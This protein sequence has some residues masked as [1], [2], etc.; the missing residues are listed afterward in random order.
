MARIRG[1]RDRYFGR[2]GELAVLSEF[3][4]RE[5][6]VAVPEVDIGQDVLV[7]RDKTENIWPVQVKSATAKSHKDGYSALFNVPFKQVV[8]DVVPARLIFVFAVRLQ[9]HWVSFVVV[10]R[11]DLRDAYDDGIGRRSKGGD[12]LQYRMRFPTKRDKVE[13]NQ[14]DR[15]QWL[16]NFVL[17]EFKFAP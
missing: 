15:T 2:S 9:H 13:V 17:E 10:S 14:K 16:D 5:Y 3:L 4:A 8:E 11:D 1:N 7:V 6:N 12:S